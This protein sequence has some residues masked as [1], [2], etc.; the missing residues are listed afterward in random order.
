M[1]GPKKIKN[2]QYKLTES[3]RLFVERVSDEE[4][5]SMSEI[6]RRSAELYRELYERLGTDWHEA[7]RRAGVTSQPIGAVIAGL[8]KTALEQERKSKK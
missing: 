1:A 6:G 8:V 5:V 7:D 2:L 4:R 3:M